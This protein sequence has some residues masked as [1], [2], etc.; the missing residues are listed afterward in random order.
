MLKTLARCGLMLVALCSA[1]VVQ[2]A[3]DDIIAPTR[4]ENVRVRDGATIAVAI[5][6]PT[7]A[8]RH[9]TLFAA[10]PYRFDNNL[11]P[12]TPQFLWRETGP[13]KWY[14]DHGYAFVH[15]DV[16]GTGRSDGEY[17]F[18]DSKEQTDFFDVI[19]WVAQQPWSDGKIGGIGQSYY[20][21]TQWFMAAQNPPH[22]ACIAPYDGLIDAYTGIAY[23]GGI[24]SKFTSAWYNGELRPLN[25]YPSTGPAKMLPW[26]FADE[27][28]KHPLYDAFWKERAAFE[29]L[30]RIKVPVFS[31]GIWA[32]VELHLQGNIVGY[33]RV[34]A[35]KKLLVTGS[36]NV[37]QAAA[38]FNSIAFH[39]KYLLPFYDWCLKGQQTSYLS[40]PAVRYHL[41][42]ANTMKTADAW[43]P[44]NITYRSYYLKKGPTGSVKSLN[45]GALDTAPPAADGGE[46][47]F[48]YP[49][50]GWR[51]GV[52]T[53]GPQG[54]DTVARDPDLHLGAARG[55]PRSG[56]TDQARSA[57]GLEQ[58]RHRLHR[59]A[60]GAVPAGVDGTG[61]GATALPRGQQGLDEGVA[62]RA[63]HA[64]VDRI[65]ALVR[66]HQ[67]RAAR[68]RQTLHV[69]S[70]CHADSQLFKKGSRIRLELANGDSS[71]TD[72][73][74]E[75]RLSAEQ[76]RQGYDFSLGRT[77]LADPAAGAAR[78]MTPG[79]GVGDGANF[80]APARRAKP[81]LASSDSC[82]SFPRAP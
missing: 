79:H 6:L 73:V 27:A 55:R 57:C 46:T 16:R 62:P 69:R 58:H 38:D 47:V 41:M 36:P 80:H 71:I 48:N 3:D 44:A 11:L 15:M 12:P 30:D 10:S 18:L 51:A 39:E 82:L 24:P 61:E 52:V 2:A 5:Y 4:I 29:Q 25:Q 76:D 54:P 67:G 21:M 72:F 65:R 37:F 40:E 17:R 32:K 49:D 66:A 34:N 7:N 35:P 77:A 81:R 56:G 70:A 45:D 63:Q 75:H 59:E 50:P 31:I 23:S 42:G 1:P 68:A 43:P 64:A 22:L 19:E 13:I 9:P 78:G 28:N 53:F 8:G 33:Q 20:A 14:L 60:V 74:F 26:D